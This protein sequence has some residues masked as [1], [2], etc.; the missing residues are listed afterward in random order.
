MTRSTVCTQSM[1]R[2]LPVYWAPQSQTRCSRPMCLVHASGESPNGEHCRWPPH[3]LLHPSSATLLIHTH[4]HTTAQL[5][6][7]V[8]CTVLCHPTCHS[9]AAA[10]ADRFHRVWCLCWLVLCASAVWR[11]G[12]LGIAEQP[13]LALCI[14]S[15]P[16]PSCAC[17]GHCVPQGPQAHHQRSPGHHQWQHHQPLGQ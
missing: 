8:H 11:T 5:W 10:P 12:G 14:S 9:I 16:T 1:S 2:P 4:T 13:A 17:Y 3:P 7:I 15:R 6:S